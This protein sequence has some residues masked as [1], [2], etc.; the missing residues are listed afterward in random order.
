[1]DL[2][3]NG[4]NKDG[5]LYFGKEGGFA[6]DIETPLFSLTFAKEGY[7]TSIID[8]RDGHELL[9]GFGNKLRVYLDKGDAWNILDSYR[10]QPEILLHLDSRALTVYGPLHEIVSNYSFRHSKVKETILIND[11]D[12]VIRFHHEVNWKDTG[13]FL[14]GCFALKDKPEEVTSDIAFGHLKRSTLNDTAVHR[15]QYEISCLKWFDLSIDKRGVSFFNKTRDGFYCKEG[16]VEISLLRST[17]YP[18]THSDQWP[19][20]YSYALYSHDKP[21]EESEVDRKA[22]LFNAP[23]FYG[24][25]ALKQG[26]FLRNR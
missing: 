16:E 14:K 21:F 12:D 25:K 26:S 20:S 7:L 8:R 5:A 19:L 18:C 9:N 17:D 10:D 23:F 13:Y 6:G 3:A 4:G 1:L 22:Y 15:A 24:K 2:P 11:K